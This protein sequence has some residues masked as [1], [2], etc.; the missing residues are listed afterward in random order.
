MDFP[1]GIAEHH[2]DS[3]SW[4]DNRSPRPDI[5]KLI[6]R[7]AYNRPPK[8]TEVYMRARNETSMKSTQRPAVLTLPRLGVRCG[9]GRTT[10]TGAG[11]T[12]TNRGP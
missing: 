1:P 12:A 8:D 9:Y 5:K 4:L 7:S 3:T 11:A 2:E 6:V 10:T